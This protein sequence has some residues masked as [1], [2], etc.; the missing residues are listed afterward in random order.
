MISG[1]ALAMPCAASRAGI[2]T[3]MVWPDLPSASMTKAKGRFSTSSK[4]F[5][6]STCNSWVAA[7]NWAPS[8]SF[9]AQRRIEATQSSAVT[10]VPSLH[11]SPSRRVKLQVSR[12]AA[13][14]PALQ[15]LRPVM[16]L[17]VQPDQ[18]VEHQIGEDPGGV[19][20]GD[21]RIEDLQL[22]VQRDP[23]RAVLR[24]RRAGGAGGQGQRQQQEPGKPGQSHGACPS[25]EAHRAARAGAVGLW[26]RF[27]QARAGYSAAAASLRKWS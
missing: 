17:A 24:L 23:Q 7:I 8:A 26:R 1:T 20:G 12:S 4:R 2:I 25:D 11:S 16:A 18:R 14:L 15:H 5:G 10:A 21:Q 9:C 3:G 27:L 19:D 6:S 22:G 13:D